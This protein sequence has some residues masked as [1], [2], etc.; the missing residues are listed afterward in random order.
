M[1]KFVYDTSNRNIERFSAYSM[2][3]DP[4]TSCGCFECLSALLPMCNGIMIVDR[5]YPDMTPCGMKFSTLAGTVGG[6]N[7]SPGFIG[8]SKQFICSKKF[9][10]A[11]G[12]IARVVWMPK[13]LK[14]ELADIPPDMVRLCVGAEHPDDV[15]AD[16]DQALAKVSAKTAVGVG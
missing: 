13:A 12:G 15:I 11:D 4:M 14:E 1:N 5:D 2:V 9:I 16:L 10:T 7:Q 8:H 6:G 3:Q